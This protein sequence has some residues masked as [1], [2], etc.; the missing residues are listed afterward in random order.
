M[1]LFHFYKTEDFGTDYSFQ[2]FTI[3]PKTY[4]WSLLQVSI[5]WND[6]AGFPYLQIISGGNGLLTIFFWVYRFGMDVSVLSRTWE[7]NYRENEDE[8][9]T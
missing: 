3:K 8:T 7:R 1:K 4:K 6:Y 9:T 5:S 2:L